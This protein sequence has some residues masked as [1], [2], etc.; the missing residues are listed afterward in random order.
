MLYTTLRMLH[1]L[2]GIF[3]GGSVFF[4]V[5]ILFPALRRA[6]VPVFPVRRAIPARILPA[7]MASLLVLLGTGV[8]MT[9]IIKGGSL[10]TMLTNKWG[11]AIFIAFVTTFVTI[12]AGFFLWPSGMRMAELDRTSRERP[13]TPDETRELNRCTKKYFGA[14]GTN[15]YYIVVFITI[16]SML[17]LRY[18]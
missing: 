1:I 17:I 3:W 15:T 11:W 10:G 18:L 4:L 9:L 14:V 12:I 16:F 13:L 6:K 7:S 2:A 5:W 8:A